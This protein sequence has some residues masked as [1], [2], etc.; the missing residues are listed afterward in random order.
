MNSLEEMTDGAGYMA[1]KPIKVEILDIADEIRKTD[2]SEADKAHWIA[3]LGSEPIAAPTERELRLL[4]TI[5][6]G[7]NKTIA[8]IRKCLNSGGVGNE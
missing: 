1:L 6:K 4:D 3:V 5:E 7:F 8:D 2:M